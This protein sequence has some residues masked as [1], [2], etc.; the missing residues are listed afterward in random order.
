MDQVPERV[1]YMR[2]SKGANEFSFSCVSFELLSSQSNI[3][4]NM[5]AVSQRINGSC[6]VSRKMSSGSVKVRGGKQAP[7]EIKSSAMCSLF[8]VE[9]RM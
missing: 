4:W 1:S 7:L 8:D 2:K 5:V 6:E 9:S 3:F